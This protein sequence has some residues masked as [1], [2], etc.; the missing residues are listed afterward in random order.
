MKKLSIL[1]STGSIGVQTLNIVQNF[2]DRFQVV[3]LGAGRNINLLKEQIDR[4][5]PQV[6]SVL[7]EEL[8]HV[9]SN[10]LSHPPKIVH[11]VEGLIQVATLKEVDLVVSAVV[12]AIGLVP[13]LSAVKAG[14]NI[15]VANKESLVMGGEIVMEEAQRQGVDILPIDS[16]HCAIFQCMAG[17][18]RK[19]VRRIILTASGGPFLHYPIDRLRDVPPEE[20]LKHPRWDMGRKVTIDSA[21]LMNKGLE[22]IEAHWLFDMPVDGIDVH[23]HPQS[24]IH[25]MVEYVDGSIV[26]Q[27]GITDMRIPISYALSYP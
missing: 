3:A 5:R 6:V 20:A 1:G 11:G 26:A 21:T 10:Q 18:R 23:V 7:T 25:S 12:G 27:M 13:T 17:H 24:I 22:I 2:S 16:E 15:A 19:D 8:G 4:F 9:L 14:K